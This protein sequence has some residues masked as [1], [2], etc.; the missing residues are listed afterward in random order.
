M[1]F[2]MFSTVLVQN[3]NLLFTTAFISGLGKKKRI[4]ECFEVKQAKLLIQNFTTAYNRRGNKLQHRLSTLTTTV[5]K[6][7]QGGTIG[8]NTEVTTA[9]QRLLR[10]STMPVI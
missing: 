1:E 8:R 10:R 9:L 3:F 7:W 4:R 6:P 2:D 5:T